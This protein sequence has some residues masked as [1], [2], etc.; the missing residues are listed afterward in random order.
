MDTQWKTKDA[1]YGRRWKKRA[2]QWRAEHPLCSNCLA[3]GRVVAAEVTD[4]IVPHRG[5]INLFWQ[6]ELTSLCA[7]CH[8]ATKQQIETNGYHRA[9]GADGWPISPDHPVYGK[10]N[11]K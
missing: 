2:R 6:G 11:P 1:L 5:D 4:H 8:S 9:I 3:Q 7:S 10:G